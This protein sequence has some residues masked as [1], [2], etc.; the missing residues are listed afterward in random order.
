MEAL[1]GFKGLACSA[2]FVQMQRKYRDYE[3]FSISWQPEKSIDSF[4]VFTYIFLN[5]DIRAKSP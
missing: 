4:R 3:E 2:A 1:P 5:C